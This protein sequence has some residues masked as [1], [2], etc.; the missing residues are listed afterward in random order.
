MSSITVGQVGLGTMGKNVALRLLD[1]GFDVIGFD[2]DQEP[3][4]EIVEHGGR[5][6]DS[7]DEL[8]AQADIVLS[9]L[10]YPEI[11][12]AAYFGPEGVF[13]GVDGE[14]I[15]IEQ[16]TIPPGAIRELAPRFDEAGASLLDVPFLSG[17]PS[18]ARSGSM[19]LPVGGPRGLYEDDRVQAVLDALSREKHYVGELGTG[20]TTK[21][22]SNMMA[23]G[24]LALGLE[25]LSYGVAQGMDSRTLWETLAYGAGSSV[26][27]RVV[28]PAALNRDFEPGFPVKSSQKD[29]RFARRSAESVDFPVPITNAI[30]EMYTM[31]AGMGHADENSPAMAKVYEAFL[32]ETLGVDEPV[33]IDYDDPIAG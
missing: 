25:A 12:E 28:L 5:A 9:A 32:E 27:F 16:S 8:G 17:G 4:E 33:E 31:G 24:N 2:I 1:E 18:F 7:N 22:V 10:N 29:L 13:E 26:M 21:L 6:A 23:L 15:C 30:H 3:L 11:V 20:K 14:V 19:V